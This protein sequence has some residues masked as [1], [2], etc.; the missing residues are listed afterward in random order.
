[1][2]QTYSY[3]V[4]SSA[5]DAQI[6]VEAYYRHT[7]TMK[8]LTRSYKPSNEDVIK[9]D[10]GLF[11]DWKQCSVIYSTENLSDFDDV[12]RL[13]RNDF[14]QDHLATQLHVLRSNLPSAAENEKGGAK[15]N[16][17][18]LL[19]FLSPRESQL[20]SMVIQVAKSILIMPAT[21]A[22]SERSFSALRCL[23]TWLRS[24][25]NQ[26]RLNWYMILHIHCDS[27][28]WL[29]LPMKLSVET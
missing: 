7:Y 24:T 3:K 27:W 4:G 22:V 18:K 10:T 15:S 5:P 14:S 17:I 13:Y 1:M 23:K 28:S 29:L 9:R 6:S 16:I 2:N 11:V 21:N 12:L 25:V 19:Q 26:S 8:W 20:Y